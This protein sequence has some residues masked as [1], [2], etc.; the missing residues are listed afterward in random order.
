MV[1]SVVRS[2]LSAAAVSR[3]ASISATACIVRSTRS[4]VR[5]MLSMPSSTR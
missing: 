5:L 3:R 4:G 1:D 2:G